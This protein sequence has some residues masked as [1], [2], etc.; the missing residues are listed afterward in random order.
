VSALIAGV[1]A[2]TEDSTVLA[3]P[4]KQQI[5]AALENEVS[6]LSDTQ[7][8]TALEGQPQPV[9]DEVT[10]INREAR[11][12]AIGYALISVGVVG[13]LGLVAALFLPR[14]AGAARTDEPR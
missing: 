14:Q 3:E 6:T 1:T 8:R 4:E 2:R 10:R 9:V 13:I 5:S 7:V 12:A 11:N